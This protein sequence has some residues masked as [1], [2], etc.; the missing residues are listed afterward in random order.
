M[1]SVNLIGR[2]TKDPDLRY[3]TGAEPK[4]VCTFT[5]AVNDP[6]TKDRAD[7]I[8]CQAWG[9]RAETI[10]KY[11]KKGDRF[12]VSG[13]IRHESYQ[14][15]DGEY[16]SITKVVVTDFD[17]LEPKKETTTSRDDDFPFVIH[18]RDIP[19]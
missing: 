18:S 11:V 2:L 9:G 12:G 17:F 10:G 8:L 16:K 5:L 14:D 15:K 6:F 1:N 7:F 19:F 13:R 3:T 4:A